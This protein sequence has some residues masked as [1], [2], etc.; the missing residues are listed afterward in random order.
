MNEEMIF[1]VLASLLIAVSWYAVYSYRKEA[2]LKRLESAQWLEEARERALMSEG[3]TPIED[4]VPDAEW[5]IE[6]LKV[7]NGIKIHYADC[8]QI[9]SV[10]SWDWLQQTNHFTH[11]RYNETSPG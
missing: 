10:K 7:V 11:W 1:I 5:P 2:E 8:T 6:L 3:W 9:G 4:C